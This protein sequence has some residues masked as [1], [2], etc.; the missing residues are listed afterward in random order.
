MNYIIL[1]SCA[2]PGL[3]KASCLSTGVH[4]N[5]SYKV[6][7]PKTHSAPCLY[8]EAPGSDYA[9]FVQ[10]Y[11]G[12]AGGQ[13]GTNDGPLS[14]KCLCVGQRDDGNEQWRFDFAYSECGT[15]RMPATDTRHTD[16]KVLTKM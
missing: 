14:G 8:G 11:A 10:T 4:Y 12:D 1:L 6:A 9:S 5:L 7:D 13:P 3:G 16:D 15:N 2:G